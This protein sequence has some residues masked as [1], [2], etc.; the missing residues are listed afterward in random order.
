MKPSPSLDLS[1]LERAI[2]QLGDALEISGSKT[3]QADPRLAL[4]LRAGAIQAFEFTYE[5]CVKM[6]RRYLDASEVTAGDLQDFNTL[7]RRAYDR[8]LVRADLATW[9]RFRADRGT[10]SHT[11]SDD[12]AQ[13]VFAAIPGFLAE[14]RHV[15]A[16]LGGR[17]P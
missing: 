8:G 2:A 7:I 1:A 16:A 14:A 5:L 6:L 11:D 10:T 12:K 17:E 3:A 13:Q 15:L 4:H 9:R